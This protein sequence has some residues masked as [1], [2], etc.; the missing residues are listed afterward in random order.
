MR[1]GKL[2][3]PSLKCEFNDAFKIPKYQNTR[4]PEHQN[5]KNQNTKIPKY[6]TVFCPKYQKSKRVPC[7]IPKNQ[8][9]ACL[10]YSKFQRFKK[11][12]DFLVLCLVGQ[13]EG[14]SKKPKYQTE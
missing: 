8:T 1:R 14:T 6:Q 7:K 13:I 5:T 3:N 10:W 11:R 12:F 4:T 2:P 9:G